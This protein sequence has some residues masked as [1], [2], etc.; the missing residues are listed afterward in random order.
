MKPVTTSVLRNW[1]MA[2]LSPVPLVGLWY[3]PKF[4]K[5]WRTYARMS[6]SE[7]VRLRDSKPCL[8]DKMPYTPF[9]AHYFYQGA[10]LGRRL[11]EL[12]S[13]EHVDVGSSIMAIGALS[14]IVHTIFVD[15]RP[16][17]VKLTN[18]CSIAANISFLPFGSES[19]RSLS[20]LHVIEHIGL[21]R[22][23]D[24]IDPEGSVKAARELERILKPGGR[25]YLSVPIGRER[26]CF[27][28][29]RVFSPIRIKELFPSLALRE[30]SWVDDQDRFKEHQELESANGFNYGCGM[31]A[32]EKPN[33]VVA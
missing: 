16:L 30:F 15:Y 29:H 6:G 5:D 19:V 28:A 26:I 27:N 2:F 33:S 3:L 4:F 31:F 7:E 21:G 18:L 13:K 8:V 23:G 9:D 20:C 12:R 32:F 10:W 24:Q 22:Y 17:M 1:A 14:A 25:L 11:K